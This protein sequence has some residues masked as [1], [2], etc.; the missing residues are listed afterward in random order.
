MLK[1]FVYLFLSFI[2]LQ[3]AIYAEQSIFGLEIFQARRQALID[4]LEEGVAVLY[5]SGDYDETGYRADGYFWY[6]TG[7]DDPEAILLLAPEA[8]DRQVLLL[9]PR[10]PEAERWT[11]F[12]V[13]LTDS[14][15]HAWGY[16][17]IARINRLS[18]EVMSQV[19]RTPVLHLISRPV[20]PSQDVPKD[21]EYYR[22]VTSRV[23]G[24]EIKNSSRFLEQMRMIKDANEI[25]AIEK[26]I[27]I[28]YLGLTDLLAAVKPGVIEF[29]L[30][31]ILE[32]SFK[33]HGA[34]HMA[35]QPIVGSGE[36]SAILHYEKRDQVLEPGQLLLLDVGAQWEH[37]CADISRTVPVD[38]KFTER[39]AQV[40]DLVLKAQLAA[41]DAVKPGALIQDVHEA[42]EDVFRK[43]GYIDYYQH[44]TSHHL[45]I[46]VHDPADYNMPL[47]PGMI[48][49]IEPG[50]Y[51]DEEEIGIRI[52]DDV[53]VTKDGYRILSEQI[54]RTHSEV[55]TWM[56]Q[57]AESR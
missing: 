23:P 45:G 36:R 1:S 38:G 53:L 40:Y 25:A 27:A 51:I 42:A 5:S 16:D 32:G 12:R 48:I 28:T 9:K 41:M 43:A 55:E 52:E 4:S 22:K 31:G 49:T 7:N 14:L 34:Q 11:G 26:A 21:L 13:S 19:K 46:N 44:G 47:A 57:A 3:S 56:K 29:Q 2:T 10:N 50:L 24:A 33:R 30:D 20:S 37:Y 18:R 39:Q 15:E 54:P 35:F 6:L 8:R 17:K